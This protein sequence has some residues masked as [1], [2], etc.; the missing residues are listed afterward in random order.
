MKKIRKST[1]L[2]IFML[3]FAFLLPI[4]VKA[5]GVNITF[6]TKEEKVTKGQ[7]ITVN[8][9]VSSESLIGDFETFIS[10]N[11]NVLEFVEGASFIAGGEGLLKLSHNNVMEG[12]K[13]RKY[14][15][16]FKTIDIGKSEISIDGKPVI[17]DFDTSLNMSVSSNRITIDVI[18][19][20]TAST[21][22]A[23]KELKISPA[24]EGF[25]F[26]KETTDYSLTVNNEVTKL[27]ISAKPEDEKSSVTIDGDINLKEGENLISLAVK[28][29]AGNITT[30]LL[31][32]ERLPKPDPEPGE[33]DPGES[34]DIDDNKI[35]L[36]TME[37]IT[38]EDKI[39][40][41]R[42]Y[43]YQVSEEEAAI[44]EG[45]IKTTYTL[46]NVT[47]P[48]Y[49]REAEPEGEF[50][51]FYLVNTEGNKDFYQ[52]DR[53]EHTLQR[54]NK[55]ELPAQE[56]NTDESLEEDIK[57]K[58]EYNKQLRKY[59]TITGV[60]IGTTIILL[61]GLTVFFLRTYGKK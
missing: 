59:K 1:Y 6:T 14:V 7:T 50:L 3:L 57:M 55:T 49:T 54:Y 32:V 24:I 51:L 23:L 35:Q 15:L 44:P 30:Y 11:S 17:Y 43:R 52:Y 60:F 29:E 31:E 18:P 8:I 5:A 46:D 26:K 21:N 38:I 48:A 36:G 47:I 12:D 41:Q 25:Q 42:G 37:V 61:I 27:V 10:Y 2:I 53:I 4:N 39:Y 58:E 16:E 40:I 13:E 9:K 28:A 22:S 33:E 45:Y 20:Q 19:E 56:D 34:E